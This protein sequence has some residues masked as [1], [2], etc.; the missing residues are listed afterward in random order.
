MGKP[1]ISIRLK[2]NESCYQED[3][4]IPVL[5]HLR[6]GKEWKNPSLTIR[7]KGCASSYKNS[8]RQHMETIFEYEQSIPIEIYNKHHYNTTHKIDHSVMIPP[9]TKIPNSKDLNGCCSGKIEYTIEV[10]LESEG[11]FKNVALA[12]QTITVALAAKLDITE[13][14]LEE[15]KESTRC[16]P[17]QQGA[18]TCTL[19]ACIPHGGWLRGTLIGVQIYFRQ[20]AIYQP[21][22]AVKVEFICQE[23]IALAKDSIPDTTYQLNDEIIQTTKKDVVMESVFGQM[24]AFYQDV[25]ILIPFYLTPTISKSIAKVMRLDYKIRVT[26]ELPGKQKA[27]SVDLPFVIGTEKPDKN[28]FMSQKAHFGDNQ[29]R[30]FGNHIEVLNTTNQ[31]AST[32]EYLTDRYRPTPFQYPPFQAVIPSHPLGYPSNPIINF[33]ARFPP[34]NASNNTYLSMVSSTVYMSPYN[35]SAESSNQTRSNSNPVFQ[36][37]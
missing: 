32:G 13:N 24:K 27:L 17:Q 18:D 15:Q 22:E 25:E 19:T 30:R 7:F 4:N 35:P 3:E 16:W 12:N 9:D 11:I 36:Y 1:E 14:K 8:I 34:R 33:P 37:L 29:S 6:L 10:H 20:P 26:I 23:F 2:E 28:N 31:Q 5:I 21:V